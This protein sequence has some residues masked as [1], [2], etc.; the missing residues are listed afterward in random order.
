MQGNF[1]LRLTPIS[2]S[3]ISTPYASSF[4]V[5][6]SNNRIYGLWHLCH[7]VNFSSQLKQRP[8][9]C[10]FCISSQDRCFIGNVAIVFVEDGS[11]RGARFNGGG[12]VIFRWQFTCSS[13]MWARLIASFKDFGLN[14]RMLLAMFGL[15]HFVKVP[16]NA[17]CVQPCIQFPSF[18][19]PFGS[20]VMS[21][22]VL[23]LIMLHQSLHTP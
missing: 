18:S 15:S 3:F 5:S 12:H 1:D 21:L 8:W 14:I 16:T 17:F 11:F 10:F 20:L 23:P 4:Q 22:L 9:A 2:A 7:A 19:F 6:S 13:C